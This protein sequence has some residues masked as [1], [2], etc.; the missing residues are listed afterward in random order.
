MARKGPIVKQTSAIALGPAEIRVGSFSANVTNLHA[1]LTSSNSLG[2]MAT[3]KFA[4]NS[5][6]F[7]LETGFPKMADHDICIREAAALDCSFQEITPMNVALAFG[8]DPNA[9]PY[10]TM[11]V[12]SGEIP[13]GG[14]TVGVDVRME[15]IYTYPNGTNY[16]KI[17]FPRAHVIGNVEQDFN[18][19]SAQAVPISFQ[20]R[21]ADI[22]VS[23]GSS[24]WNDRP[25]G[26][27]EWS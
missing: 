23:G 14:R 10:A 6:W 12:H 17:I 7:T 20:A 13:L 18:D 22:N 26:R 19:E 11:T 5:D 21:T 15:A 16:M 2:A 9:A 27:V 1:A 8:Y 3:T 24:I 25:L 4:G